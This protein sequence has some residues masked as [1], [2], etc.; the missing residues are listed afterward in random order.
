MAVAM[1]VVVK[2]AQ[3]GGM[4]NRGE[5]NVARLFHALLFRLQVTGHRGQVTGYGSQL[6]LFA[7]PAPIHLFS[8]TYFL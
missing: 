2:I 7:S 1:Y 3:N 6:L 5:Y 8:V 4:V